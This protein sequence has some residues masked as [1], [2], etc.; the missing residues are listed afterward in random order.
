[1]TS[2]MI[3]RQLL[4]GPGPGSISRK[5]ISFSSSTRH[6]S[7]KD[8]ISNLKIGKNTRVIFQGFTGKSPNPLYSD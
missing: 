5:H 6:N 7:Y 1:M 3:G 4:R 8:T 2:A